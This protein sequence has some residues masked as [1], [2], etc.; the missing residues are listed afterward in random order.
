MKSKEFLNETL[1][2][3]NGR[4]AL[5]S[6]SN[7]KKVLQYYRGH[8]KPS[9]QWVKKVEKRIKAITNEDK[10]KKEPLVINIEEATLENDAYRRVLYTSKNNQVVVMS[11]KPGE[12]IGSEVHNGAQ[13]IRIEAGSGLSILNGQEYNIS[14][15]I[16]VDVPAGTE[17][18]IINTSESEDLKLYTVYSPPQHPD[19]LIEYTKP[20]K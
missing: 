11:I 8:G 9:E 17:H 7:P 6:K 3:V 5:V 4:W 1:K 18:N 20:D 16:V 19:G 15:G 13:F 10:Q 2:K 14:D 12:E